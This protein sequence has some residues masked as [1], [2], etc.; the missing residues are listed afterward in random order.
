VYSL[1]E[2]VNDRPLE[3][4][5]LTGGEDKHAW[6]MCV[7]PP[8]DRTD[9]ELIAAANSGDATAFETLYF[10]YRD[11]VVS[12]A[13]RLTGS[14]EDAL[15]VLQETYRYF[16]GKFPG[17]SL[18]ARLK[19]FL[20]PVVKHLALA[21]VRTRRPHGLP[22]DVADRLAAPPPS[23]APAGRSELDALLGPLGHGEREVVLLRFVDDLAWKEIAEVLDIPLGT[24]NPTTLQSDL[25][26]LPGP[27]PSRGRGQ[28]RPPPPSRGRGQTRPPPPSRGRGQTRPP[29]PSVGEGWG[30]G[31]RRISM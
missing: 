22:D 2:K 20:Y 17:F 19:T 15:D 5:I 9:E 30:G 14:R 1:A 23:E 21:T 31:G 10:R 16:F 4:A 7:A 25:H 11:W 24:V 13:C 8:D 26:P 29:P 27:P 28:T 3:N 18:T 6:G 12:L